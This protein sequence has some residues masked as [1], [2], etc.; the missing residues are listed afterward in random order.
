MITTPSYSSLAA[1]V[2]YLLFESESAKQMPPNEIDDIWM[3]DK[4]ISAEI[5][6]GH[7]FLVGLQRLRTLG[8]LAGFDIESIEYVRLSKG[9]LVLFP[10]CYPLILVSSWLRYA[11]NLRRN[12]AVP[13]SVKKGVYGEQLRINIGIRN[14][15]SR[16]T[17]V[18]F[19]KTG[20]LAELDFRV[21]HAVKPFDRIM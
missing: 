2:S 21:G 12:R 1:K 6:H 11:R 3:S 15:L 4:K 10:L 19:N 9:S 8:K 16:H 5:Y 17:F 14:L 7:L 20:E 18:V 13:L